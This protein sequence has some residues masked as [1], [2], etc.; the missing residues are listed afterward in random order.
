MATGAEGADYPVTR[1]D[2]VPSDEPFLLD[3]FSADRAASFADMNLPAPMLEMMMRQQFQAQATGHRA[4]FPAARREIIEVD[5]A[6]VGRL[7]SDRNDERLHLVDIALAPGWRGKGLGALLVGQLIDEARTARLPMSL[8]VAR[9]NL[10]AAAL[11]ARLGFET[12]RSDGVY[13]AMRWTP[14]SA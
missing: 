6:C 1:R 12:V 4:Q 11:Y 9:D 7:V 2:E 14:P 8:R 5:G 10:R 3:L 13:Q